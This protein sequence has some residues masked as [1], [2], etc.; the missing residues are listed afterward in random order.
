M[1]VKTILRWTASSLLL[2]A[3]AHA[4]TEPATIEVELRDAKNQSVGEATL[5]DTPNGVLI[6]LSLRGLPPGAHGFHIHAVGKCEP[7]FES[8][9]GH[10]NPS[11]KSHG[12]ENAGGPHGGDLPNVIVAADGGVQ[13]EVVAS[14]V[15]LQTG[16][17]A[18]LDADGSALVVHSGPDDYT[19][20]PA[21]NSGARIACGVVARRPA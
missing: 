4:A 16:P 20:D 3:L 7:P 14:G 19:T 8:A 15:T 1:S 17:G 18:L 5:R 21:G 11:A 10:F 2:G 13:V 12:F 9:G 6:S